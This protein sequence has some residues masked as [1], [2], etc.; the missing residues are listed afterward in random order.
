MKKLIAILLTTVFAIGTGTIAGFNESDI[1]ASVITDAIAIETVKPDTAVKTSDASDG[2][3]GFVTRLYNLCLNREP[4]PVGFQY[5][6]SRLNSGEISARQCA[7][8]FF[9][10]TEFTNKANHLTD[11]SYVELFYNVFLGRQSD[12]TGKAYWINRISQTNYDT[13]VLFNGFVDSREFNAIC[14]SYGLVLGAPIA[15]P[16][17]ERNVS[18]DATD[19]APYSGGVSNGVPAAPSGGGNGGGGGAPAPSAPSQ[20]AN[21]DGQGGNPTIPANTP[22]PAPTQPVTPVVTGSYDPDNHGGYW[23]YGTLGTLPT[24]VQISTLQ[25]A[26]GSI[27]HRVVTVGNRQYDEGP[28]YKVIANA[29]EF[30]SYNTSLCF[31]VC[32][33][34]YVITYSQYSQMDWSQASDPHFGG[35]DSVNSQTRGAYWTLSFDEDTALVATRMCDDWDGVL[36]AFS[37]YGHV[38]SGDVVGTRVRYANGSYNGQTWGYQGWN[39]NSVTGGDYSRWATAI[40]AWQNN[41]RHSSELL[42]KYGITDEKFGDYLMIEWCEGNLTYNL[43]TLPLPDWSHF[44]GMGSDNAHSHFST[45]VARNDLPTSRTWDYSSRSANVVST[46][47]GTD[48]G[49]NSGSGTTNPATTTQP[50]NVPANTPTTSTQPIDTTTQPTTAPAEPTTAPTTVPTTT[51]AIDDGGISSSDFDFG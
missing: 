26:D 44:T 8:G 15:L 7:Y 38:G 1:Q 34:G 22:S 37:Y 46:S 11:S 24:Q 21:P 18:S 48:S 31:Y 42:A 45:S 27:K 17:V 49:S 4:D 20:P 29:T 12:P 33:S 25:N 9:F 35:W 43:Q 14:R 28:I 13:T 2:V 30:N 50:V 51:P 6:T 47:G 19:A 16:N 23:I 32:P 41:V 39:G 40:I 5:W 10:S 36:D 3:D